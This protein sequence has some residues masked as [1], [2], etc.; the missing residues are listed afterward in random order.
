MTTDV[1]VT[2]QVPGVEADRIRATVEALG[3]TSGML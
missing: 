1:E 2:V 3:R